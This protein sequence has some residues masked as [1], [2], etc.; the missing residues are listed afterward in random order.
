MWAYELIKN[1]ALN[2][3]SMRWEIDQKVSGQVSHEGQVFNCE[4]NKVSMRWEIDQIYKMIIKDN[5]KVW[6]I[7]QL[8]A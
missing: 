2:K 3:V 6:K 4:L 8:W 7:F 5:K 1:C